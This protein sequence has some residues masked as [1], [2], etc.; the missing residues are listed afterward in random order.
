M[1]AIDERAAHLSHSQGAYFDGSLELLRE[2]AVTIDVDA[3]LPRLSAIVS[4]ML[5]HDALRMVCRDQQGRPIVNASTADLPDMMAADADE[6]IIGDLR[7]EAPGGTAAPHAMER[8]VGAGYRSVLGVS[9]LAPEPLVRVAFWSKQP[10]AFNR[11]HVPLARRIAYHLGLGTQTR[12]LGRTI[13]Q[14][15]DDRVERGDARVQRAVEQATGGTHV[16]IVGES[17]EWRGVL[18]KATQVAS[19]DTTV[20]VTGDVGH[21]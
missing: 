16:H 10:L 2:L 7:S 20:L 18:R 19:T 21:R 17:A 14:I 3:A 6:V 13:P 8:L 9:T 15:D 1:L 11:A 5:P 12:T 4:K